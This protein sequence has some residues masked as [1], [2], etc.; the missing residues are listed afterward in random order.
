MGTL[1]K[2]LRK[3]RWRTPEEPKRLK[4]DDAKTINAQ[5][6]KVDPL[7]LPK[8][9]EPIKPGT[10]TTHQGKPFLMTSLKETTETTLNIATHKD[11]TSSER[12]ATK[13]QLLREQKRSST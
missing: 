5:Q 10:P 1:L 6:T 9:P 2:P 3:Q 7:H 11:N 13:T 4:P 8:K 12:V